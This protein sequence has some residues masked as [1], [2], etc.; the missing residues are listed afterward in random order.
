MGANGGRCVGLTTL[1]P[2]CDDCL[3]IWE[4]QPPRSLRACPGLYRNCFFLQDFHLDYYRGN[5]LARIG[6]VALSQ[7]LSLLLPPKSIRTTLAV[8]SVIVCCL[9]AQRL[10]KRNSSVI[11]PSASGHAKFGV[12]TKQRKSTNGLLHWTAYE[13]RSCNLPQ[14]AG[15]VTDVVWKVVVFKWFVIIY[16]RHSIYNI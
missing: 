10:A 4:P 2:S 13:E 9:D 16:Y 14:F 7:Q 1:L 5:C 12:D 15:R 6:E 3:E 11:G 8:W